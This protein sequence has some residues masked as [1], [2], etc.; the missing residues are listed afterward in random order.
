ML[1]RLSRSKFVRNGATLAS[2]NVIAQALTIGASPILTRLFT[3]DEYGL[4]GLLISLSAPFV[5]IA[6]LRYE[7]AIVTA[8]DDDTAAKILILSCGIVFIM[9]S[10]AAVA[11]GLGRDWI[12]AVVEG[13]DLKGLIW[14]VPILIW[15]NGT[16]GVLTYWSVRR[17]QYKRQAASQVSASLCTL[18]VQISAGL[19]SLGS[20]GLV[21]GRALGSLIGAG[22]VSFP[23]WKDDRALIK[24]ELSNMK[25]FGL[26]E[27]AKEN[28]QF[29]KYNAPHDVINTLSRASIPYT[30]APFFGVE[31]VGFY[32]LAD[33]VLNMPSTIVSG[34]IRKVFYQTASDLH[35][36][37]KSFC[38]LFIS[39]VGGMALMGIVPATILMFYAPEIF[40]IVFGVEWTK[41]GEMTQW[42]T[43]WWFVAFVAGPAV[44]A[45]IVLQLQ[46]YLLIFRIVFS[47]TR[48]LSI[49]GGA[50]FG[51]EITAIAA[52]SIVGFVFNLG[53]IVAALIVVWPKPSLKSEQM[54]Q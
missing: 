5:G 50:M 12:T 47:A 32:L 2:G 34:S 36:K 38:R 10:L 41:A 1:R 17:K 27:V 30:L 48:V 4:F 33:R 51:D 20:I 52:C 9:G 53:L 7:L 28:S 24:S 42:L 19:A 23:I 54:I 8:K 13:P 45:L 18:G 46:K 25:A 49:V 39:T 44:N 40:S 26:I 6:A 21:T 16:Y 15:I 31:L 29:P 3:P 35:N 14:W 11:C 37:G 22:V 43:V